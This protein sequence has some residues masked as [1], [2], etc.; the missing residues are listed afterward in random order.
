MKVS[1]PRFSAA[2]KAVWGRAVLAALL[3]IAAPARPLPL[4]RSGPQPGK[5]G[6]GVSRRKAGQRERRASRV[7]T[8]SSTCS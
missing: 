7:V 8:P 4:K 3:A 1:A 2:G 5:S 6:N